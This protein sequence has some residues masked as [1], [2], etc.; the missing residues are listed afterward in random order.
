MKFLFLGVDQL[1]L[2]QH[3]CWPPIGSTK[4][5]GCCCP[6]LKKAGAV[7][8]KCCKN[9]IHLGETQKFINRLGLLESLR[10]SPFLSTS[11]WIG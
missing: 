1:E 2:S 8:T 7:G 4:T 5:G 9:V 3:F 6:S 10:S 11:T